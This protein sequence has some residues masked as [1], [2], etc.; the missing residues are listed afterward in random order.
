MNRALLAVGLLGLGL[1]IGPGL[2]VL[3]DRAA[4]RLRLAP[5]QRCT[6]C[7]TGL[8]PGSLLPGRWR[9]GCPRCHRPKGLRYLAT[10]L[11]TAVVFAVLA[12]RFGPDWRLL[13]HLGLAAVLVV[14]SVIDIETHRL[15]NVIMWPSIWSALFLVLV[16][17]GEL[18]SGVGI[19]PALLGGATFGG[20]IGAAHL[21]HE[22]GMGRGDVKLS[23]LLGLFVGWLHPDPLT[24][25]RLVLYTIVLALAGGAL[26]GFGIN[27]VRRRR[28]EEFP[29]GPALASAALAV[30]VLSPQLTSGF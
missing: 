29:F 11:T 9:Q 14:L 17:S 10:D 4:E 12:L 20:F 3:V 27:L 28:G 26:V 5:E 8:G 18:E 7:Q 19:G 2:G 6:H 30:I 16:L 13:P 22:R 25:V 24:A 23:L 15:P 21:V 1:L